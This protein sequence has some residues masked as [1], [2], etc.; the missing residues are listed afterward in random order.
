MVELKELK[1]LKSTEKSL[2]F[3]I[4]EMELCDGPPVAFTRISTEIK[5]NFKKF[6]SLIYDLKLLANEQTRGSDS[7][8]IYD[9]I[10]TAQTNL[11]R[12]QNLS[13]KVTLK[14]KINQ[15]EKIN[16]ERK[17]L[18]HGGKLKKR[19]NVKDDRALTDSS[20]ELTETLRKAVDMMKAEVEKGNDSLEEISNIIFKK[21]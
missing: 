12:L 21:V 17:E 14:S 9:N 19:L 16:L 4:S 11:K 5:E 3:L 13:R 10:F 7:D 18:L 2:E 1:E 8:F 20:T 15:E 6:E